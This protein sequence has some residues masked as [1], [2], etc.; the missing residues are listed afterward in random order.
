MHMEIK[1]LIFCLFFLQIATFSYSQ[2]D[3][4]LIKG[5]LIDA[6][7]RKPIQNYK[8]IL[9]SKYGTHLINDVTDNKGRFEFKTEKKK[10]FLELNNQQFIDKSI[11]I[12]DTN[13][14]IDLE[15]KLRPR[16]QNWT[17]LDIDSTLIKSKIRS[18]AKKYTIDLT[19]LNMINEP[20]GALRGFDFELADS[21]I[22]YLFIDRTKSFGRKKRQLYKQKIIG[23]GVARNNGEVYFFGEGKPLILSLKNKYFEENKP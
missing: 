7:S 11:Y 19:D 20:P 18:I 17:Y 6:I 10:Y 23:I 15:I 16:N 14:V 4:V 2:T 22:I 21:T 3:S 13:E 12:T 8:V 1:N 5:I 9:S